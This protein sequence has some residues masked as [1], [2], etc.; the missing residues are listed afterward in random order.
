MSTIRGITVQIGA[1]TTALTAAL[2]DVN[3]ASYKIGK[4]LKDIEKMLKFNPGDTELLA[5]K[6]KLLGDQIATTSEK[7]NR[8]REVQEQ[9]NEQF[10][11]GEMS[12]EQHRA[13]QREIVKT[14]SQLKNYE[15][16]LR[17]V[18]FENNEFKQSMDKLGKSLDEA[19]KR[20]ASVG[21]DLTKKLTVPLAGIGAIAT[22]IGMDFESAMSKVQ[23]SSGASAK[24][25]ELL[26]KAA[27]DAGASTSKSATDAADALGYMALAGWDTKTSIEGLMP[28]LRLSEAGNIDLARASSL[29]TDSMSAMGIQVQDLGEYLDTIAQT[30]RNSNTNIDQMAEAY[31]KVGGTLRGLNVP[32]EESSVALGMMAN[33]GIKGSEAGAGLNAILLNLTAPAGRAKEALEGLGY[34]AFDAEGNFKGLDKVLF[35]LKDMTAGMS[36]EQ[37]NLTLAMIGGKNHTK[38]LNALLNG[39]DDS[40][41]DLKQA[42]MGADGALNDMAET[43]LDNTKGSLVQLQSALEELALKIYDVMQPAI[44]GLIDAIRGFVGWLDQLNPAVQRTVIV[45]AGIAAAIGPVLIIFGKLATGVGAVVTAFG[46]LSAFITAKLIP[47]IMAI[48]W[49]VVAV[50]G[51]IVG[52]ATVAYEV[53]RAWDEVKGALSATWEYLK[54]QANGLYLSIAVAMEKMN[55][56]TIQAVDNMLEKLS[57]LEKLP[58]GIGDSF[59]GLRDGVSSNVDASTKKLSELEQAAADNASRISEA[60]EGMKVAFGDVGQKIAD[61]V[62]LAISKITGIGKASAKEVDETAEDIEETLNQ[63]LGTITDYTNEIAEVTVSGSEKVNE[64]REKFEADWN[65]KLFELQADRREKLQAEYEEAIALA[66]EHQADKYAIEEYYRILFEKLDEDEKEKRTKFEVSWQEKIIAITGEGA[67]SRLELLEEEQQE[68]LR[69][70]EELEADVTAVKRY[71][72]LMRKQILEEEVEADRKAHEERINLAKSWEDRLLEATATE[73][74]LLFRNALKKIE[75]IRENMDKE[76]ELADKNQKAIAD[77]TAFWALEEQKVWDE[78]YEDINKSAEEAKKE[79]EEIEKEWS[80]KLLELQSTELE[81]K[82]R[83]LDEAETKAIARAEETEA[84]ITDIVASYAIMRTQL[85]EEEQKRKDDIA[86]REQEERESYEA[87]WKKKIIES[88]HDRI[89]ILRRE[90]LAEIAIAQEKKADI[91]LVYEYYNNEIIKEEKRRADELKRI[92]EAEEKAKEEARTSYEEKWK[93]KLI[94]ATHDRV[95]ILRREMLA[96]L[97]IAEEKDADTL[98]VTKYYTNE[99]NKELQRRADEAERIAK[100]KEDKLLSFE[101]G[102]QDKLFDL[103]ATPEMRL[104]KLKVEA[105][106]MVKEA[107]KMEASAET[108]RAIQ[109]FYA[110]KQAQL[111]EKIAEDQMSTWERLKNQISDPV[112]KLQEAVYNAGRSMFEFSSHLK[113]GNFKQAILGVLMETEAFARGME[114]IGKIMEPIIALFDA[115]LAPMIKMVATLLMR[116]ANFFIDAINGVFRVLNKIPFVNIKYIDRVEW[117]KDPEKQDPKDKPKGGSG[118]RQVSEITGPTRDLFV[119]LLSPLANLS[120]IVA[121]LQ[122]IRNIL[123]ARLPNFDNL[124]LAGAGGNVNITVAPGAVVVQGGAGGKI[125]MDDLS[126]KLAKQLV[127]EIRGRGGR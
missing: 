17:A 76:I 36:E 84:D 117:D 31:I 110:K 70:A 72:S 49:P 83:A 28:V 92:Q 87:S 24:E 119:D 94:E 10:Q 77:I 105:D 81:N 48:N 64:E 66:K 19:G 55:L 25:M 16:Q 54:A 73:E 82:L 8:L 50:V 65:K 104:E 63:L 96:E 11:K 99:I 2:R 62:Q 7:L 85:I 78:Y 124:A 23:A 123:D 112:E 14:E 106:A 111:Q 12:E 103:T 127:S 6:Q 27:R 95:D 13:F 53:Y 9:V 75:A 86:R 125:D 90:M 80:A 101:R 5:Q 116:V 39:L 4:E 97:K 118:G 58:L 59:K 51:A 34:S 121:P 114:L 126:K 109:E 93:Q 45:I 88:S 21:G 37:R 102:W 33:A 26:E 98:A 113:A 20:M 30:A 71:F 46:A 1:D 57:S 67:K 18:N 35:D 74:D 89:D 122:D 68:A 91:M 61:D 100:E 56:A 52:L 43:M 32:I 22:K 60:T 79:R 108:I 15:K 120:Q 3:D 44:R 115:V 41:G 38:D 69:L 29:V 47:A 107:E 42:V 40:Y